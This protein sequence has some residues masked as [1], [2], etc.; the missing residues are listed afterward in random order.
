MNLPLD[1]VY[2]VLHTTSVE[3]WVD[4]L[5]DPIIKHLSDNE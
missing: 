2:E 4:F 5:T 3:M 1:K